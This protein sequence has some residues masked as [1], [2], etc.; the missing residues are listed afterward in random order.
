MLHIS[1]ISALP[2]YTMPLHYHHSTSLAHPHTIHAHPRHTLTTALPCS[3]DAYCPLVEQAELV[4][5][6]PPTPFATDNQHR[7]SPSLKD[8]LKHVCAQSDTHR[9]SR[10]G[11][12]TC[13][14]GV[15]QVGETEIETVEVTET[16]SKTG[17]SQADVTVSSDTHHKNAG[18]ELSPPIKRVSSPG[19]KSK[20][21]PKTI[22]PM[23]PR[24]L[25]DST[26]YKMLLEAEEEI[27]ELRSSDDQSDKKCANS[28]GDSDKLHCHEN[29]SKRRSPFRN[30]I[31]LQSAIAHGQ[32]LMNYNKHIVNE[33][34]PPKSNIINS[35]PTSFNSH[36]SMHPHTP[37]QFQSSSYKT[38]NKLKPPSS[39][40]QFTQSVHLKNISA[41]KSP[42]KEWNQYF[43]R[44]DR[45]RREGDTAQESPYDI[46]LRRFREEGQVHQ[47]HSLL[48][49]S[50]SSTN[51][52]T[53]KNNLVPISPIPLSQGQ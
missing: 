40:K 1:S 3:L 2:V 16:E 12:N 17:V 50:S 46:V 26:L 52:G 32:Q 29:D 48:T 37:T 49:A 43:T 23:D 39:S 21:G 9:H 14:T 24:L 42:S 33:N 10:E 25:D 44:G 35:P 34:S 8:Q 47:Q 20:A 7:Q 4:T 30:S 11:G 22:E 6:S 19:P 27:G 28:N 18:C 45:A 53:G 51:T 38:P 15:D 13:S 36:T 5:Q 41:T 31:D